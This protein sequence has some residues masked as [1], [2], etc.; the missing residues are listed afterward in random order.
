MVDSGTVLKQNMKAGNVSED[1]IAHSY[2]SVS[3]TS[4]GVNIALDEYSFMPCVQRTSGSADLE[5]RCRT[6]TADASTP[7][8]RLVSDSSVGYLVQYRYFSP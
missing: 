1:Q 7:G 8:F 6:G 2:G 5:W 4:S 3:G